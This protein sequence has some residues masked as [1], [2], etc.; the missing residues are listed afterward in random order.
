MVAMHLISVVVRVSLY[1]EC[2]RVVKRTRRFLVFG[3]LLVTKKEI[4]RLDLIRILF[5]VGGDRKVFG[6]LLVTKKQILRLDL[7]RILFNVGGDRTHHNYRHRARNVW[8]FPRQT[9]FE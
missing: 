2:E 5:N 7:I 4:L 8:S 9:L 1:H 3:F 6:F